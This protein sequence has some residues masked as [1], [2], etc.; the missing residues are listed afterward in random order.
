MQCEQKGER[1][2]ETDFSDKLIRAAFPGITFLIISNYYI[3]D[4]SG[5][6]LLHKAKAII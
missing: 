5:S 4:G 3:S 6:L 1:E 2:R